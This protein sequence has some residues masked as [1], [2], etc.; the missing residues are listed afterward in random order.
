[1]DSVAFWYAVLGGSFMGTYPVPIKS[2]AVRDLDVHPLVF[3]WYKTGWVFATGVGF[4]LGR[5][6]SA[7]EVG[8]V[9]IFCMLCGGVCCWLKADGLILVLPRAGKDLR[10]FMVGDSLGHRLGAG[11]A[12][13]D[14]GR[15]DH[16]GRHVGRD[17]RR[18]RRWREFCH[19][20]DTPLHP[21]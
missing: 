7:A 21:Y 15:P 5:L 4:L 14:R 20:T 2:R 9:A 8:G 16:W 13:H 3:A 17:L 11:R 6:V 19:F 1:M 18:A 10:L 12:L